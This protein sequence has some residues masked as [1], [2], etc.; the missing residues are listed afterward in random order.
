M[1]SR[2]AARRRLVIQCE[3]NANRRL[4]L[5]LVVVVVRGEVAEDREEGALYA[6]DPTEG[7]TRDPQQPTTNTIY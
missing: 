2:S 6:A 1:R 3:G 4:W 5:Y 7:A